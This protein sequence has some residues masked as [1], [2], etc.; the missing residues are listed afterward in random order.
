MPPH[1]VVMGVPRSGTSALADAL[2]FHREIMCGVEYIGDLK[3]AGKADLPAAFQDPGIIRPLGDKNSRL[4]SREEVRGAAL[5]RQE[6]L[7]LS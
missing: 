7:V 2:N 3:N 6:S 4:V 1:F 5:R